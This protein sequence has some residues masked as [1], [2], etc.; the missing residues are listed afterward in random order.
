MPLPVSFIAALPSFAREAAGIGGMPLP[1]GFMIKLLLLICL[2][3]GNPGTQRDRRLGVIWGVALLLAAFTS[4]VLAYHQFGLLCCERHSTLRQAMVLLALAT[5]TGLLGGMV[6]PSRQ[7][8]LAV[9]L[10]VLFAVRLGPLAGDWRRLGAVVAARQANWEAATGP[11]HAMTLVVVGG[12]H[13]TNG[14]GLRTGTFRRPSGAAMGDT[15]WYAWGIMAR[16][17]KHALTIEQA[18]K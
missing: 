15:P 18:K 6:R 9:V 5:F 3:T 8:L 17:D 11:G 7:L 14:D 4:V 1:V 13:I 16:F 10:A 2:P 12:G